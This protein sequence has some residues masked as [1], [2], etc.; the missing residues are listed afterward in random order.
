MTPASVQAARAAMGDREAARRYRWLAELLP[1]SRD[2]YLRCAS[3][4]ERSAIDNER[5]AYQLEQS[6]LAATRLRR[7]QDPETFPPRRLTA[8]DEG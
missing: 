4:A 1:A 5:R 2:H 8:A 7:L 3:E 6:E